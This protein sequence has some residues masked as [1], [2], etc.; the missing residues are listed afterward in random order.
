[1]LWRNS[2]AKFRQQSA[3]Q[4]L[5]W[6][7]SIGQSPLA[8]G[9]CHTLKAH[10][11]RFLHLCLAPVSRCD[12]QSSNFTTQLGYPRS[13]RPQLTN[14]KHIGHLTTIFPHRISSSN[15]VI[16]LLI[17]MATDTAKLMQYMLSHGC[18]TSPELM[19]FLST[20]RRAESSEISEEDAAR[21]I[22][23]V[24]E[25][26]KSFNMMIR[27]AYDDKTRKRCY[28]LIST[29]DN[30]ITRKASHHTEKELEYFRLIWQALQEEGQKVLKDVYRI[31]RELKLTNYKDL[32][33]EWS[34]KYWLHVEGEIVNLGVRSNLELDVLTNRP[35]TSV[36]SARDESRS[37]IN[38]DDDEDSS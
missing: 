33:D 34:K 37:R 17:L 3:A 32:I 29:V 25:K 24:N 20:L 15:L 31:G 4:I 28:A 35:S 23:N 21:S 10:E 12:S 30:D 14:V 38:E 11:V 6:R 16:I 7:S 2:G 26:I 19:T 36:S 8:V 13:P 9:E 27:S 22:D 18:V 1:M 5:Q